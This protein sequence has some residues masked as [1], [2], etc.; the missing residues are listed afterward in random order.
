MIFRAREDSS[1]VR[2]MPTPHPEVMIENL[3][4]FVKR[5]QTFLNE[6]NMER[7][8]TE[9]DHLRRHIR[10]GCLSDLNP[11]EGT[12]SNESLHHVSN[13]WIMV[14][15]KVSPKSANLTNEMA[16]TICNSISRNCFWLL[17]DWK[18]ESL[19]NSKENCRLAPEVV[20]GN[21]LTIC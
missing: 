16:L 10:K 13:R 12:E 8:L 4:N 20:S 21:F 6:D 14:K 17:K 5:W 7:T 2:K 15:V 3:E 11:G 1:E 18:L 9:I 19:A